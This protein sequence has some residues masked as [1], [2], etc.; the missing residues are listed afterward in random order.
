MDIASA[1]FGLSAPVVLN[2][3]YLPYYVGNSAAALY[4]PANLKTTNNGDD[5][6]VGRRNLESK[7]AHMEW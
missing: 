4:G 3:T 6:S 5:Y 1:A 2:S 7:F